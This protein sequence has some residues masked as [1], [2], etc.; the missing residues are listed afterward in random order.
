MQYL[1]GS[2]YRRETKPVYV[3]FIHKQNGNLCTKRFFDL[4]ERLN[5]HSNVWSVITTAKDEID[6]FKACDHVSNVATIPGATSHE[7]AL[8]IAKSKFGMVALTKQGSRPENR[9]R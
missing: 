8:E 2:R 9:S 1:V 7:E 5:S 6:A 4:A 3:V